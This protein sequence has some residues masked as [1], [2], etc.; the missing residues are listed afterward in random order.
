MNLFIAGVG[1]SGSG[2]ATAE[3]ALRELVERLPGF[4]EPARIQSW[5]GGGGMAAAFVSHPHEQTGGIEY[6]H[7]EPER[8]LLWSGRPI[9]W[10]GERQADGRVPLE[11]GF[12]FEGGAFERLDGRCTAVWLGGGELTAYSDPMGAYPLYETEAGDTT[13]LS[14]SAALLAEVAGRDEIAPPVL[15]SVLG[16]GWSLSGDPVWA[17]VRRVPRGMIRTYAQGRRSRDHELL[18]LGEIVPMLGAGFDA[19]R[20]AALL[21]AATRALADWP[22]RP[23]IVPLTGGRD[24]RLVFAAAVAADIPFEIRTGG[25]PGDPDVEV[26]RELASLSGREHSLLEHDPHGSLW[27]DWR[28]AAEVVRLTSSGTAT[29]AD[30]A[31]YPLGPREGPLVLWHSGQGGEIARGYYGEA[32][33]LDRNGLAELLYRRFVGRRPGRVEPLSEEGAALVRRQIRSWVDGQL[34]AGVEPADVPDMFYLQSE[35]ARGQGPATA[36]WSSSATPPRRS[37]TRASCPTCSACPRPSAPT[38]Y[39]TGGCSSSSRR[40]SWTCRSSTAADGRSRAGAWG[41]GCTRRASLRARRRARRSGAGG[42]PWTAAA[43]LWPEGT[44]PNACPTRSRRCSRRCVTWC[45]RSA[46]TRRGEC[47]TARVS[48]GCCRAKPPRSTR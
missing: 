16:G 42:A 9:A 24:S 44:R 5:E 22:G 33:A 14:N 26:A 47:S 6:A 19:E 34:D 39:F 41:A 8:A 21:I 23:S 46:I 25:E 38:S 18:P 32:R 2:R 11:A 37:G 45:W 3:R 48:S 28:R 17:R 31:G 35:W 27:D 29:L 10:T 15:A 12:W 30:A 40:S 7:L 1:A 13:W 43:R 20:A 36:A 4:F